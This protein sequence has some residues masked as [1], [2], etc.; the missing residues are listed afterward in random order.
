MNGRWLLFVLACLSLAAIAEPTDEMAHGPSASGVTIAAAEQ[1]SP[2]SYDHGQSDA[3]VTCSIAGAVVAENVTTTVAAAAAA[4]ASVATKTVSTSLEN[5]ATTQE[6]QP[7]LR[8]RVAQLTNELT[9]AIAALTIAQ[10]RVQRLGVL[11]REKY[12]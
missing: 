9:K 4:T 1:T 10:H 12:R 5:T 3:A 7:E 8:E 2:P 11:E 6:G